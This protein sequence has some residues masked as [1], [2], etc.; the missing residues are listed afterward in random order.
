MRLYIEETNQNSLDKYEFTK[1]IEK[2]HHWETAQIAET[3]V[4]AMVERGPIFVGSAKCTCFRVEALPQGGFAI[5]CEH[6][7][8]G[9]LQGPTLKGF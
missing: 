6:P 1:S 7:S 3:R 5:S 9:D 8:A 4:K 2:A